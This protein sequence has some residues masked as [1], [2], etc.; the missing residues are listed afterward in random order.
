MKL[1]V[2]RRHGKD[3]FSLKKLNENTVVD[4]YSA[5]KIPYQDSVW[6]STLCQ[7]I[8]RRKHHG[9]G[10]WQ[11]KHDNSDLVDNESFESKVNPI[12]HMP[13]VSSH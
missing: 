9:T 7:L 6:K 1:N 3:I 8:S 5:R 4:W 10:S 13:K 11:R 12:K 2:F